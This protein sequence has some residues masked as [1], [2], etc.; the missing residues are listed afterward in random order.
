MLWF[1]VKTRLLMLV[2]VLMIR[3][4]R[5]QCRNVTCVEFS[6]QAVSGRW[7]VLH[8][9]RVV[10]PCQA[11]SAGVHSEEKKKEEKKTPND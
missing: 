1:K 3:D 4:L 8:A 2:L 6:A 11:L 10:G 7:G 5:V 9:G